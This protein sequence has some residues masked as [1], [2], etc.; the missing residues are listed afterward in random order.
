MTVREFTEDM[1]FNCPMT[2][3]H[4]SLEWAKADIEE[5]SRQEDWDMPEDIT[6]EEYMTIWNELLEEQNK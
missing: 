2:P 1:F 6:P 4:M 3:E 5:L